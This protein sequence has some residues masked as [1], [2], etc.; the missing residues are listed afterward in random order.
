MV[1]VI[2]LHLH[3]SVVNYKIELILV[4]IHPFTSQPS[5]RTT[6]CCP[7]CAGKCGW[8]LVRRVWGGAG[9]AGGARGAR[10]C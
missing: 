9:A 8:V 10:G 2:C 1:A 4:P 6:P 3:L 7:A 5:A